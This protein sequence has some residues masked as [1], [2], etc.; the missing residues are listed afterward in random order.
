MKQRQI[1]R[2]GDVLLVPVRAVPANTAPV[3][4]TRGVLQLAEGETT[5][6]VHVVKSRAAT[7]RAA[8]DN[9][10]LRFLEL[11]RSALLE[12]EWTEPAK[13]GEKQRHDPVRLPP[14][15]Y[16]VIRQHEY[17]QGEMERVSD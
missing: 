4:R 10:A 16:R 13:R 3:S 7:L 1:Y 6:H 8:K 12:C 17:R 11:K 14:G 9:A 2:Q 15:V 5:A